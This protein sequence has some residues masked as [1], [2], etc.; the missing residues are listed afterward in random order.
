MAAR[1][2]LERMVICDDH[3]SGFAQGAFIRGAILSA[4]PRSANAAEN[5]IIMYN[6]CTVFLVHA[7]RHA[8]NM[9]I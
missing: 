2:A 3:N 4:S 6:G 8:S 9:L 5:T 7:R 1:F